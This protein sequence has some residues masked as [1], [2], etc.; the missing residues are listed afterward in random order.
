M[1]LAVEVLF[2]WLPIAGS[3][4][5]VAWFWARMR[6]EGFAPL[7]VLIDRRFLIVF[8]YTGAL[9]AIYLSTFQFFY[10]GLS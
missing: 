1:S 4:S 3:V 9:L 5:F 6:R 8:L 7:Q 10:V 2:V